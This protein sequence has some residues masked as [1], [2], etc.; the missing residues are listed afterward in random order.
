MY[1][2]T[3]ETNR[4]TFKQELKEFDTK[5]FKVG[6]RAF[7]QSPYYKRRGTYKIIDIKIVDESFN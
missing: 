1:I 7:T 5:Y 6:M 3:Y 4:G 2:V